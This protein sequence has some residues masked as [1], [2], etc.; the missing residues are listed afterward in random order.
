MFVDFA[1]DVGQEREH[2]EDTG[3]VH[4]FPQGHL[5]VVCDGMGG[6]AA[7]DVASREA[8]MAI[9]EAVADAL[10]D[11]TAAADPPGLLFRALTDANVRVLEESNRIRQPGMGTTA[12]V[13]LVL[14]DLAWVGW[15][16][17]SRLYHYRKGVLLEKT[18]DHTRV[19]QMLKHGIL[20]P[21]EAI[22]HPD[23]HILTMA[24]GGGDGA[25][26]AFRP[27]VWSAPVQ[28]G[29]GDVLLLCSDGLYDLL[30]DFDLAEIMGGQPVQR[31]VKMLVAEANAKGGHDNITVALLSGSR[32][33]PPPGPRPRPVTPAVAPV[34]EEAPPPPLEVLRRTRKPPP[35]PRSPAVPALAWGG[36]G[37]GLLLGIGGGAWLGLRAPTDTEPAV[38]GPAPPFPGKVAEPCP[39]EAP[40]GMV[41]IEGGVFKRRA[42]NSTCDKDGGSVYSQTDPVWVNTFFVDVGEVTN[43][44]WSRC[45]SACACPSLEDD[46]EAFMAS[47]QPRVSVSWDEAKQYCEALGKRLITETEWDRALWGPAGD[48][49]PLDPG[50][51]TC[52]DATLSGCND[53]DRTRE[54]GTVPQR[55]NTWDMVGNAPEWTADWYTPDLSTCET[56]GGEN[57]TGPQ[58]GTERVL[59]GGTYTA[60]ASCA[61]GEQRRGYDPANEGNN[62][63]GF[64]CAANLDAVVTDQF[65]V[66]LEPDEFGENS[67]ANKDDNFR[68]KQLDPDSA[69]DTYKDPEMAEQLLLAFNEAYPK[70]TRLHRLGT[71][72]Q[73]RPIS[74]LEIT[75][76]DVP[77][78][79][80]ARVLFNGGHHGHELM[81]VEFA[82]DTVELLLKSHREGDEDAERWLQELDV[83]IV[84]VVNPDGLWL[85]LYVHD[86]NGGEDLG[87]RK[88]GLDF[89]SVCNPTDVRLGVDL[90]RNYPYGWGEDGS[91]DDPASRYYRGP[92]PGSEPETRAMMALAEAQRFVASLTFHTAYPAVITPYTVGKRKN[93]K[94]DVARYVAG[95]IAPP[96]FPVKSDLYPVAGTD[97][98]WLFHTFG[99][100][101][102]IIEGD[103][104][105][106]LSLPQRRTSRKTVEIGTVKF[107]DLLTNGPR[108]SGWVQDADGS[109]VEAVVRVKEHQTFE[110]EAW[111]SRPE[112]GRFD[113]IVVKPGTY[114][115]TAI[116]DDGRTAEATVDTSDDPVTLT[117]L[118]P[119]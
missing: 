75:D 19:Q 16:G 26:S 3:K 97:Q 90:N 82:F 106:P 95:L 36:L 78:R 42:I 100:L 117:V 13:C 102:F 103:V 56:C 17:D 31:A 69:F 38:E 35:R 61:F 65:A 9:I 34:L 10:T 83:W 18:E 53:P 115:L 68:N 88:N 23:S 116:T 28:I 21:E 58:T 40:S 1:T 43:Q 2:N 112:D 55:G 66:G 5:L 48:L 29:E 7:G 72:R 57:P 64:R 85:T 51:A 62:N 39:E 114:T 12:V 49:R 54:M 22:D 44:S 96:G 80:K 110:D 20:T 111:T 52:E 41:C 108:L 73:G 104:H 67:W 25:Q 6:H 33:I 79:D 8:C 70:L 27:A 77:A 71:S 93:P 76:F 118:A 84:P 45:E 46:G 30:D 37:L 91:S 113:R 94:P 47:E 60:G 81:S 101:A 59:K 99:T 87:G 11:G 119:D 4:S 98:D 24:L 14:G 15:V 92:E 109:P 86:G 89:P 107:L 74:A 50:V 32:L 105:N 63:I